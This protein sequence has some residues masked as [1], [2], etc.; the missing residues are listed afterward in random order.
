MRDAKRLKKVLSQADEITQSLFNGENNYGIM[1]KMQ[2]YMLETKQSNFKQ[3]ENGERI[4]KSFGL[5]KA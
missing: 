1:L 4:K 3:S 2:I 5:A